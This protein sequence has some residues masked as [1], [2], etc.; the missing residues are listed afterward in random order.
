MNSSAS[1]TICLHSDAGFPHSEIPGSKLVDS[2]PGL[3]AAYRVLLRLITPRHP[4]CT[5]NS[6]ITFVIGL[7]GRITS[8]KHAWRFSVNLN[9]FS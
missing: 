7:L 2:S 9:Y 4:P 1:D 3:I 5:L 6:L 8:V